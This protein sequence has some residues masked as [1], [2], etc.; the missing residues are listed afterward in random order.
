MSL[1]IT[2]FQAFLVVLLI[3]AHPIC[4]QEEEVT[5]PEENEAPPPQAYEGDVLYLKN[6]RIMSGVQ[7]LNSTVLYFEVELVKGVEPLFIRR[8]Q[9]TRV[10]YDDIDPARSRLRDILFPPSEEVTLKSGERV[11]RYLMEKLSGPVSDKP[12]SYDAT[13]L[14][15][16]LRETADRL[17]VKLTIHPSIEKKQTYQRLWTL[18]TKPETTLMAL[19]REHLQ[20]QFKFAEVLF[21]YDTILVLTKEAARNKKAI[22]AENRL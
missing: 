5:P 17:R 21:E 22:E 13:D 20:N 12:L 16:I 14:I 7:I 10:E 2:V 4:A 9:V 19:L 18:T 3:H 6:G 15:T 8:N 1:R 11:S